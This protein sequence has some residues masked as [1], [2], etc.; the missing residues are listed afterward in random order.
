MRRRVSVNGD[1]M[2]SDGSPPRD[3]DHSGNHV[4]SQ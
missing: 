4:G 3:V 1:G 2:A